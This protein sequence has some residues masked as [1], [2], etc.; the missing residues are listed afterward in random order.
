MK[1]RIAL[2]ILILLVTIFSLGF[3]SNV[4][5]N[6]FD[7]ISVNIPYNVTNEDN[8]LPK[9]GDEILYNGESYIIAE[10]YFGA[11]GYYEYCK[12]A[13]FNNKYYL[14][15]MLIINSFETLNFIYCFND[16]SFDPWQS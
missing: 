3:D 1:K 12:L 16:L 2:Y 6:A 9:I 5:V 11:T 10:L 14:V 13:D 15:Q 7:N 4:Q 8:E